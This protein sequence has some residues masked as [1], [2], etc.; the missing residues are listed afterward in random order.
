MKT[1]FFMASTSL[2]ILYA[3]T[4]A[5]QMR[6]QFKTHLLIIDQSETGDVPYF[7]HL[8]TWKETPF[9]HVHLF[10]TKKKRKVATYFARHNALDNIRELVREHQPNKI[11][12]GNDRRLEFQYAMYIARQISPDTQG[13]YIDD[14]A[15]S[16]INRNIKLWQDTY[17]EQGLRKLLYGLWT[18]SP[19]NIGTSSLISSSVVAFP[20]LV[21]D[22]LQSKP[23]EKLPLHQLTSKPFKSLSM[24]LV[25]DVYDNPKEL[26]MYDAVLTLPHPSRYETIEAYQINMKYLVN[27][28]TNLGYFVGIKYHPRTN[29]SDPLALTQYKGVSLIPSTIGFE[30]LIPLLNSECV[31]I[32]DV[33]STLLNTRWLRPEM[34]VYSLTFKGD[35]YHHSFIRLFDTMKIKRFESVDLL[36]DTMNKR[37]YI[38]A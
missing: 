37:H 38:P 30:T 8:H 14:G 1:L 22:A 27:T 9:N 21:T 36:V 19:L 11:Y 3:T 25:R 24:M 31:V 2:H 20:E 17:F 28:M 5:L 35:K 33:S 7:N 6:K 23:L 15:F 26:G 4:I 16:Y 10:R 18:K 34:D 29:G 32:G 13:I 12:I